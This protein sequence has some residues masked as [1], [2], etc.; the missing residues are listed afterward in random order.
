MSDN[1]MPELQSVTTQTKTA[2]ND[3]VSSAENLN[4]ANHD[5]APYAIGVALSG[6]GARGFAHAGALK[7][8]EEAGIK[9]DIIA[10]VSAGSVVAALY[11]AGVKPDDMMKLFD[12]AALKN[13]VEFKLNGG[14]LLSMSKF[15]KL[16]MKAIGADKKIEDLE[17]PLYIGAADLDHAKFTTFDSGPI[18]ERVMASC[19]IPVLFKPVCI[20][21]TWYVDGGVLQNLPARTIRDKCRRLIGVN[22][23]PMVP[24]KK[25]TSIIDVAMRTYHLMVKAN[26][27]RDID[28]CDLIVETREL[29]TYQT[30][31]IKDREQVFNSGYVN[32]RH[33]LRKAG[34]WHPERRTE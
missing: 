32:M 4:T 34:W 3:A 6:G 21:G 31:N 18:G 17:M 22:V 1:P 2:E 13:M 30:F 25:A 23:I 5:G 26:Q 28:V 14:G 29:S 7:A 24:F 8:I 27:Q 20:D 15:I 12:K 9:V 19:S 33:A 16:I 11:A 10:G